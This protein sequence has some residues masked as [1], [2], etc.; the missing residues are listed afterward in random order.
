M[1][2]KLKALCEELSRLVSDM[3]AFLDEHEDEE[4]NLTEEDVATYNAMDKKLNALRAKIDREEKLMRANNFLDSPVNGTSYTKP[5]LPNPRANYDGSLMRPG[6]QGKEYRKFFL[7]A[8]RTGFK[9]GVNNS[10]LR[11]AE[12]V[13]GG[14]LVPEEFDREIVS[15]LE[16]E[17]IMRKICREITTQSEHQ[18]ALVSSKPDAS[19]L[20]EGDPINLSEEKFGQVTLG[21]K[22]LGVAIKVSNELLQDAFIDLE[23]HLAQEFSDAFARAEE[24]AFLNGTGTDNQ[25]LGLLPAMEKSASSF[26]QTTTT[27]ITADDLITLEFSLDRP[28]RRK[29]CWLTSDATLALIRR[30][31]DATQNYIWQPSLTGEEPDKL[32]GYPIHSTPFMP[33]AISGNPAIL[34]GDFSR[35]AIAERGNRVFRPLRE[36]L[37][38]SD[39]SA[40][41]MIERVDC[42]LL[43]S[44]A[45]RGLKI[46]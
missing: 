28:Y 7:Q 34:F 2:E 42:A 16:Q 36:L 38:L 9:N 24:D 22:K 43:D 46:R 18:I 3:E 20:G 17:N 5:I 6:V 39:Q 35:V 21:A 44:S 37:A 32:L 12:L 23:S 1:N 30:L 33:A 41:L 31:K 4:G 14:F 19:W 45:I 11:E 25:P 13:D 27:S 40:F 29:A 10:Y 8:V 15:R 26:I